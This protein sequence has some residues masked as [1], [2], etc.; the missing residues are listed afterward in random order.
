MYCSGLLSLKTWFMGVIIL[1][2]ARVGSISMRRISA[3]SEEALVRISPD[4]LINIELPLNNNSSSR[5]ILFAVK[6][7]TLFINAIPGKAL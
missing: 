7:K 2:F 6:M 4:G 3:V 1:S 5:P